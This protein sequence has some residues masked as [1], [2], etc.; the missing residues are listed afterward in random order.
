MWQQSETSWPPAADDPFAEVVIEGE[1]PA[2]RP[3]GE[4]KASAGRIRRFLEMRRLGLPAFSPAGRD[5][6]RQAAV[7]YRQARLMEDFEDD[8]QGNHPFSMYFPCYQ[9]M[10]YE[11]WRTYFS[12]RSR[13]R[14]GRVERT[15][16]SYVFVY[17]YE[18]IHHIGAADSRD[19]LDKLALVW[20]EY[21][22]FEPKLDHYLPGWVKDYYIT[23][24][25]EAPFDA[26]IGE[27]ERLR[28]LYPSSE[29]GDFYDFYAP[30]SAYKPE[31]SR[32]YSEETAG[33][34]RE[35]FNYLAASLVRYQEEGGLEW[36]K[37]LFFDQPENAWQPFP[38][39]L[40]DPAC[41]GEKSRVV[42]F[43]DT[44]IYW[45]DA[46]GWRSTRN[47]VCRG[48]GKRLIGQLFKRVEQFYREA[49]HYRYRL[50]VDTDDP[51]EAGGAAFWRR[52]DSAIA[53]FYRLSH[54]KAVTVDP[55]RLERIRENAR[56]TQEK[57]LAERE[58]DEEASPAAGAP[59]LEGPVLPG[60][61]PAASGGGEKAAAGADPWVRLVR[62]FTP[63]EREAVR[64]LLDGAP[65]P[66]LRELARRSGQMLEVLVDGL[67][68]KALDT[69][70]DTLAE[71]SDTVIVYEDYREELERGMRIESE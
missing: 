62:S 17:L 46:G 9:V 28:R 69:V 52:V 56:I 31:A 45:Y 18:L 51:E 50:Q 14:R 35:C 71:L 38:K 49:A 25:F 1:A 66:A 34:M 21:R 19:G 26:V 13:V 23:S 7:F 30:L 33:P 65:L 42:R 11:Q 15:S 70:Q 8:Y 47:R 12:W 10:D 48:T 64:L 40:Y 36:E 24:G 5:K 2:K 63:A 55:L 27:N 3:G 58:E 6:R 53:E 54:R 68:Q 16:F 39:A 61:A 22:V 59:P 37:L 60:Q 43:S 29:A 67:N 57:L 4:A 20:D 44:E 41:A 32:F